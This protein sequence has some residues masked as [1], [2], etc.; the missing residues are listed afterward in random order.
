[1]MKKYKITTI[2]NG[3]TTTNK[4]Y[5]TS[6]NKALEYVQKKNLNII[7]IQVY[8]NG[9]YEDLNINT[10]DNTPPKSL[11]KPL[12]SRQNLGFYFHQIALLL[13]SFI[14]LD[15]AIGHIQ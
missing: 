6:D 10:K 15:E 14:P 5:F 1:M 8:N 13:D 12:K 4:H 3:K 11:F 2:K 7:L 9:K